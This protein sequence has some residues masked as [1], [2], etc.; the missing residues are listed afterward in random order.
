MTCYFSHRRSIS[1][2][3]YNTAFV[4]LF[5]AGSGRLVVYTNNI[6]HDSILLLAV[7]LTHAR[8]RALAHTLVLIPPVTSSKLFFSIIFLSS[9]NRI[10][11]PVQARSFPISR[12]SA[13]RLGCSAVKCVLLYR[14]RLCDPRIHKY[15]RI[16]V[17]AKT[18]SRTHTYIR[19][20]GPL[21]RC[22]LCVRIASFW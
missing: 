13:P 10:F 14:R 21:Q 4:A 5:R 22:K 20:L 18:R 8:A 12:R 6:T 1:H 7:S 19:V 15:S 11:A 3:F 16:S 17:H 9:R 2:I